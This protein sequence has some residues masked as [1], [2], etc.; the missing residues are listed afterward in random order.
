MFCS[1]VDF[2]RDFASEDVLR[3]GLHHPLCDLSDFC[4]FA[5]RHM[6][7]QLVVD[8]H[9]QHLCYVVRQFCYCKSQNIRATTLPLI[10]E[11]VLL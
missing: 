4:P 6:E 10:R 5:C 3:C 11:S 1:P 8:R 7:D 2:D 9:Q